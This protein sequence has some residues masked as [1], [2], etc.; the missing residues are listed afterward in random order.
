M[1]ERFLRLRKFVWYCAFLWPLLITA[2]TCGWMGLKH[3]RMLDRWG[4]DMAMASILAWLLWAKV[5]D[6]KGWSDA[7]AKRLELGPRDLR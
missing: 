5:A 1:T 2:G 3:A 6:H 7:I 4:T